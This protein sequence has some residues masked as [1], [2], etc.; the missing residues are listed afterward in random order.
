MAVDIY[1]YANR[2]AIVYQH[3]YH[4]SVSQVNGMNLQTYNHHK[5]N[6]KFLYQ[7]QDC[8]LSLNHSHFISCHAYDEKIFLQFYFY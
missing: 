1:S 6:S 4:G 2:T 7:S 5:D 3:V 8:L